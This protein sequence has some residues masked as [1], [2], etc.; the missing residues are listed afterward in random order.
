MAH[1]NAFISEWSKRPGH[2]SEGTGGVEAGNL[3][4]Q[5]GDIPET[6]ERGTIVLGARNGQ[7]VPHAL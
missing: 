7:Q 5:T 6:Q 2:H 3:R 4:A 1:Q